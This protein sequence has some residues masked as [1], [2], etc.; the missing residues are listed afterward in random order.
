MR[1][2]HGNG[3][4]SQFPYGDGNHRRNTIEVSTRWFFGGLYGNPVRLANV[5]APE[6]DTHEGIIAKRKLL[7]RVGGRQIELRNCSDVSDGRIVCDVFAN[8]RNVARSL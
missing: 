6:P 2:M 5:D 4:L 7:A 3:C 1:A 8:G